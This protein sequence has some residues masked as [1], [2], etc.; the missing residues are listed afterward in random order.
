MRMRRELGFALALSLLPAVPALA[1]ESGNADPAQGQRG[2]MQLPTYVK[3]PMGARTM[4]KN[5]QGQTLGVFRDH[6][7]DP[8][9]GHVTHVAVGSGDR[10]GDARLV[11]YGRFEWNEEKKTLVLPLTA[12]DLRALPAY[13]PADFR[14]GGTMEASSP[15][16]P[17]RD[18]DERDADERRRGDQGEDGKRAGEAGYDRARHAISGRIPASRLIRAKIHA[19]ETVFA[20]TSDLVLEP[21]SGAI[22]FVLAR[23]EGA[24]SDPFIVP[25]GALKI[26]RPEKPDAEKE[27]PG[28]EPFRFR[29]EA[30]EKNL[31]S[32]PKLSNG[33]LDSIR[34]Y[35]SLKR[36]F[37]FY[38]L[39]GPAPR[40]DVSRP[41]KG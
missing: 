17:E 23:A 8:E 16:K 32:A 2:E 20:T 34:D 13:D 14:A 12:E 15:T 37:A 27:G 19:G 11:P 38:D 39:E 35:E 31:R 18:A 25:W 28:E 21:K 30:G 40:R 22:A 1:Q 10:K 29:I 33:K 6:V 7:V 24:Q 9:S 41:E 4:V 36:I 5:D 3:A 26:E